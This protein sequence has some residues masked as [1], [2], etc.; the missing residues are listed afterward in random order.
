VTGGSYGLG[1]AIA[2]HLVADDYRVFILARDEMRLEEAVTKLSHGPGSASGISCDVTDP[3]AVQKAAERVRAR[4]GRLDFLIANAGSLQL[5]LLE[6]H[7]PATAL[8]DIETGLSGAIL[9]A[10]AFLPLLGQGSKALFIASGFG[11][12]GAAGYAPYC[13]A[14][15][16]IINFAEALRR[17]CLHRGISVYAACPSDIETPGFRREMESLLPWL[18]RAG[19]RGKPLQPMVAADR[20]LRKCR[21]RRLLIIINPEIKILQIAKRFLPERVLQLLVDRL[22]PMPPPRNSQQDRA[23]VKPPYGSP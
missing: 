23:G 11:L 17:E 6:D 15:A 9:T 21:G 8:R 5:G 16:G 2:E 10:L 19:A 1:F 12:I 7:S 20:I 14:N 22:F 3:S 4:E 13:A 18:N